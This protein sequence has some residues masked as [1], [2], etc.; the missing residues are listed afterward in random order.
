MLAYKHFV[1]KIEMDRA[2]LF[3]KFN[4]IMRTLKMLIE[5]TVIIIRSHM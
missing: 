1:K 2:W 4:F 5:T 3:I